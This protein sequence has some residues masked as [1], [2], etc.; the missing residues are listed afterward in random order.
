[1][2][3]VLFQTPQVM[4]D[5]RSRE[6]EYSERGLDPRLCKPISKDE[7]KEIIKKM[8]NRKVEEPDKIP[9]EVFRR[10]GIRVDNK[11]F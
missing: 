6:K 4:E 10:R 7:I 9:V 2:T 1:M 5:F 3:K 11:A 8:T